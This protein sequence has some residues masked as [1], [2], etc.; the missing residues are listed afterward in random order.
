MLKGRDETWPGEE[1][2]M[3]ESGVAGGAVP[4]QLHGDK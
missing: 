4:G 1:G 3:E 2:K